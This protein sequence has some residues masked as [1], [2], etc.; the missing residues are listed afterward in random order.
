MQHP[1]KVSLYRL[2][3][4]VAEIAN[5]Y[6]LTKLKRRSSKHV[7]WNFNKRSMDLGDL[8]DNWSWYHK[9][10]FSAD[11]YPKLPAANSNK[12]NLGWTLTQYLTMHVS[13]FDLLQR[14]DLSSSL[15]VKCDGGIG[16]PH[17]AQLGSFTRYKLS[18]SQWPGHLVK[19]NCTNG[20]PIYAFLLMLVVTYGLAQLFCQ[21][22]AF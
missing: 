18:K 13:I 7:K 14:L 12:W 8:I 6:H 21:I 20:L 10:Q 19:R 22:E 16:F 4:N 3:I 17:M 2:T 15:K 9:W 1:G 11:L 5:S